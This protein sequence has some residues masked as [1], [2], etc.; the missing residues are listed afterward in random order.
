MQLSQLKIGDKFSIDIDEKFCD[1]ENNISNYMKI[2]P[3]T[4][5]FKITYL[6][7]YY[8]INNYS[9]VLNLDSSTLGIL[10]LTQEVTLHD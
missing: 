3:N 9:F 6:D 4:E 5:N 8:D 1:L 10:L 2:Y 7:E